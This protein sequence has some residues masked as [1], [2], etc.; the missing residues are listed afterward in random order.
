MNDPFSRCSHNSILK[1]A[2]TAMCIVILHKMCT[3]FV[4]YANYE[5]R[6]K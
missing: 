4:Y 3:L 2:I 6:T 1:E 5:Q